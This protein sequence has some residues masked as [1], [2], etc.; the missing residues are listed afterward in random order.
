MVRDS[1]RPQNPHAVCPRNGSEP[2]LLVVWY[3]MNTRAY[4][5]LVMHALIVRRQR[6]RYR[7]P[8]F[9]T[10]DIP[11][12]YGITHSLIEHHNSIEGDSLSRCGMNNVE[13]SSLADNMGILGGD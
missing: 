7:K 13:L 1:L 2:L 8:K 9:T 5:H 10:A 6:R 12:V 4:G 3:G 11:L